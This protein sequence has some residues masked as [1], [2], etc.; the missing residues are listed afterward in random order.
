[1]QHNVL[2]AV[3]VRGVWYHPPILA[4]LGHILGL[5]W[6]YLGHMSAYLGHIS[7]ISRAYLWHIVVISWAYP[8]PI[9]IGFGIYVLQNHFFS[10]QTKL[11]LV[12]KILRIL[13]CIFSKPNWIWFGK[14]TEWNVASLQHPPICRLTGRTVGGGRLT[15]QWTSSLLR[16]FVRTVTWYIEMYCLISRWGLF[17]NDVIIILGVSSPQITL[18]MMAFLEVGD[19]L[20]PIIA[21]SCHSLHS[22]VSKGRTPLEKKNVFFHF[23][24][25]TDTPYLRYRIFP[26]CWWENFSRFPYISMEMEDCKV[27]KMLDEGRE[28]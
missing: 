3:T 23:L 4:Y 11:E 15:E 5:S 14:D 10:F 8:K 18:F 9:W 16:L 13:M 1:M 25:F 27:C 6:A 24:K 21:L 17:E 19:Q 28:T 26:H 22:T 7:G 12:W 2:I 20:G